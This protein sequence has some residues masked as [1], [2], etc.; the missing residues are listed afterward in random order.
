MLLSRHCSG[1]VTQHFSELPIT[2][3]SFSL[4]KSVY[5]LG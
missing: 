1:V 2:I 3:E 4:M 5:L